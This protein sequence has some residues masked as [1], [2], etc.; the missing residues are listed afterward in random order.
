MSTPKL[1]I[2]TLESVRN[3]QQKLDLLKNFKR[4]GLHKNNLIL[5]FR[6]K[7]ILR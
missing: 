6:L 7:Y 3:F 2:C 5:N 1:K 4:V